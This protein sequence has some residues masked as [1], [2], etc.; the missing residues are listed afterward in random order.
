MFNRHL[1]P[2]LA[3]PSWLSNLTPA[4]MEQEPFPLLDLLQD[5]FY[6][7]AADFDR[8]P[9]KYFA[10]HFSSFVYVDYGVCYDEVMGH[11]E[12]QGFDGYELI[13][14]PRR[15][16]TQELTPEGW[17]PMPPA[18]VNHIDWMQDPFC[19][20]SVFQHCDGVPDDH[21][22]YR[23]SMLY[24]CADGAAAFQALY[25]PNA[26]A[27][28]AMAIIQPGYACGGNYTNFTDPEEILFSSVLLNEGGLPEILVYGG[29]GDFTQYQRACWPEYQRHVLSF[30]LPDRHVSAWQRE[31]DPPLRAV[32]ERILRHIRHHHIHQR[33]FDRRRPVVLERILRDILYNSTTRI[34]PK[35]WENTELSRLLAR[36]WKTVR[37]D[38]PELY[39]LKVAKNIVGRS[40][41]VVDGLEAVLDQWI[42]E[43]KMRE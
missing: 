17:L 38:W 31:C 23:F 25:V 37:S 43:R 14:P 40:S 18:Q 36:I 19:I 9:V 20:W 16:E 10:G 27:P 8:T 24:L 33:E 5:S 35:G 6:Y 39:Q 15:V 12:H 34:F 42:Q 1:L 4:K 3:I 13:G 29:C 2:V 30:S 26:I 22:P 11:L 41:H 28:K 32:E 21:G 7:P